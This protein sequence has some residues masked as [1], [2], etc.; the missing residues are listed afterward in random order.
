MGKGGESRLLDERRGTKQVAFP[1]DSVRRS[2][3]ESRNRLGG[4]QS[5]SRADLLPSSALM[6]RRALD[7]QEE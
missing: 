3:E 7:A 4:E 6:F 1:F 5:S 2:R